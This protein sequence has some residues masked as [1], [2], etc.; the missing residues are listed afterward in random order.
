VKN[1][2]NGKGGHAYLAFRCTGCGNCCKEPLLPLTDDDCWRIARATG[3]HP[4]DFVRWV[5]R[6]EI[7]MDDEP[8]AFVL[9]RPGRRVMTLAHGRRGCIYLD[10]EDRCSIYASRPLGCRIFPFDPSFDREGKLRRLKLIDAADCRYELD[11][12]NDAD[13]LRRLHERHEAASAA[14]HHKVAEWNAE[15]RRRRRAGLA[16]DV[17]RGFFEFLGFGRSRRDAALK[18]TARAV[19]C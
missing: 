17:A 15:Q 11:G 14:Y 9:L 2:T 4:V 18:R 16:P 3:E 12:H 10:H 8:E 6:F 19:A 13:R 1:G 7:E 5:T